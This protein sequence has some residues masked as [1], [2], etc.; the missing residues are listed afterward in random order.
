MRCGE[1][2]TATSL[3]TVTAGTS[4]EVSWNFEAA[5]PGDCSLWISYDEDTA[6]PVNWVKV[7]DYVGCGATNAL[8]NDPPSGDNSFA[9][10]LPA[11][12][13]A[14][15]HCVMRWDWYTTQQVTNVEFYVDC[16]DVT[17][18]STSTGT[19]TPTTSISGIEYYG[20]CP[21]YNPYDSHDVTTRMR[22]PAVW[23]GELEN[24]GGTPNDPNGTNP[25]NSGSQLAATVALS[26]IALGM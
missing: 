21:F 20:D 5:H 11:N 18:E 25:N 15:D 3:T 8:L 19:P 1:A 22:G 2:T 24:G 14:C 4:F 26:V 7:G 9:F 23:A 16:F 6:N 17:V 10:A 12:L 13:P